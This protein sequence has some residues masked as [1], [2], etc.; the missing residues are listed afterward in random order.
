MLKFIKSILTHSKPVKPQ[1][2][3]NIDDKRNSFSLYTYE[4]VD[5]KYKCIYIKK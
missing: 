4:Y 1:I 2:I 5:E 3:N